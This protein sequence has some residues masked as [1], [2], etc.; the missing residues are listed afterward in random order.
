MLSELQP[1]YDK[2]LARRKIAKNARIS[3][4]FLQSFPF[5]LK[6]H[7]TVFNDVEYSA[8]AMRLSGN[9]QIVNYCKE[10]STLL[11]I[12]DKLVGITLVLSKN[13]HWHIS[14]P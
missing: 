11:L 3:D 13:K 5:I 6:L 9:S 2:L 14:T 12:E 8:V 1:T 4:I 10:T 7:Q